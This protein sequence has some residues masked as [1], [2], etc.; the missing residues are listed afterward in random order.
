MQNS[1][2]DYTIDMYMCTLLS[3][4]GNDLFLF[5]FIYV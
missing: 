3:D 5:V 2:G 4:T 1:I